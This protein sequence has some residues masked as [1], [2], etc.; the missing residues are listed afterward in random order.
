MN[1]IN[2]RDNL[3]TRVSQIAYYNSL[4]RLYFI[5]RRNL[6]KEVIK[7]LLIYL[8]IYVTLNMLHLI[9]LKATSHHIPKKKLDN[10]LPILI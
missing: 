1:F 6:S 8:A 10:C 4:N 5:F 2:K 7:L 3:N 9:H